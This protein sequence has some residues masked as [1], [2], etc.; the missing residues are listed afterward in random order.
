MAITIKERASKDAQSIREKKVTKQMLLKLRKLLKIHIFDSDQTCSSIAEIEKD[1]FNDAFGIR[2]KDD[3][4]DVLEYYT[5]LKKAIITLIKSP[6]YWNSDFEILKL[7]VCLTALCLNQ[8]ELKQILKPT[9]RERKIW[10][11]CRI[12]EN[13]YEYISL[14]TES[15]NG[16]NEEENFAIIMADFLKS[17][18]A[19]KE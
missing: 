9:K 5:E 7:L 15:N 18:E 6:K 3:I 17:F 12:I 14:L 8:G 1:E 19:I 16:N 13:Y 10:G 2:K 11:Y 4:Y